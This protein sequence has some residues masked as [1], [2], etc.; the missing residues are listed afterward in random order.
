MR[1]DFEVTAFVVFLPR[2]L[3]ERAG[4]RAVKD[5]TAPLLPL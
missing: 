3:W 2:P 1:G 5:D 4:V